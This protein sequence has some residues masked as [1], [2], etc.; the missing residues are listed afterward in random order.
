MSRRVALV[1]QRQLSRRS[2]PSWHLGWHGFAAVGLSLLC[3]GLMAL[4]GRDH[5]P[6][7]AVSPPAWAASATTP[8]A[9]PAPGDLTT[10][11]HSTNAGGALTATN[12]PTAPTPH[13][14]ARV[15]GESTL[16]WLAPSADAELVLSLVAP[17]HL[18]WEFELNLATA[19]PAG[20]NTNTQPPPLADAATST[21][22]RPRATAT[23]QSL[24]RRATAVAPPTTASSPP[25]RP[26]PTLPLLPTGWRTPPAPPHTLSL[27]GTEPPPASDVAGSAPSTAEPDQDRLARHRRFWVPVRRSA[28]RTDTLPVQARLAFHSR[29]ISLYVDQATPDASG[30]NERLRFPELATLLETQ[31]LPT[32]HDCLGPIADVDG[33]GRLAVLLTPLLEEWQAG[34]TPLRAFVRAADFDPA[35]AAPGSNHADVI[36]LNRQQLA[37]GG[38]PAIL[39]H[40]AAHLACFTRRTA[41]GLPPATVEWFDEGLA[42]AV[43]LRVLGRSTNLADRLDRLLT[44]PHRSPLLAGEWPT[45][46]RDTWRDPGS[47]GAM[48]LFFHWL[49]QANPDALRQ[50]V[51][52]QLAPQA[53]C[54]HL[55][56][57]PFPELFARF[58]ATLQ[59]GELTDGV[60]PAG[61]AWSVAQGPARLTLRGSTS[62]RVSCQGVKAGQMVTLTV[63]AGVVPHGTWLSPNAE[64]PSASVPAV[65]T[66]PTTTPATTPTEPARIRR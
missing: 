43:E 34:T 64:D 33:D 14:V 50:L 20:S 21:Q 26:A 2:G 54:A 28:T 62:V 13:H 23:D 24:V 58:S 22:P 48:A 38:L 47:R 18:A 40:E 65:A 53:A 11:E 35:L 6:R 16:H 36:Y 56:G 12:A 41:A 46:G 49:T 1:S 60:R 7:S 63:P 27:P 32:V 45:R 52:S 51:D 3:L 31:V 10:R 44:S 55:G 25:L 9:F 30:A 61:E 59:R 37:A 42:H 4:D 29:L 66:L 57:A 19:P 17:A 8:H 5:E 39:L 15:A